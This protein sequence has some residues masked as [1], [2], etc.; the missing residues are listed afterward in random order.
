MDYSASLR[1]IQR[2]FYSTPAATRDTSA[3]RRP[4]DVHYRQTMRSQGAI[5]VER[6]GN[7]SFPSQA[8]S[9]IG[10]AQRRLEAACHAGRASNGSSA[11]NWSDHPGVMP[12]HRLRYSVEEARQRW[13]GALLY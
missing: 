11:V 3:T 9:R 4:I 1:K 6:P 7:R 5:G 10:G 2:M 12:L 13:H 8:L